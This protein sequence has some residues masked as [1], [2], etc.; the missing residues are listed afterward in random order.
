M[1]KLGTENG[2][3]K[4]SSYKSGGLIYTYALLK[5]EGELYSIKITL[6]ERGKEKSCATTG[7]VFSSLDPALSFYEKLRRNLATPIDL[8]YVLEDE[9]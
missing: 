6:E 7:A 3:V 4:L 8:S 9:I 5:S 2:I 1:E